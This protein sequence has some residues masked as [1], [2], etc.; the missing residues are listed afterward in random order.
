MLVGFLN[1]HASPL[2]S[3]LGFGTRSSSPHLQGHAPAAAARA[4]G[5]QQVALL[6]VSRVPQGVPQRTGVELEADDSEFPRVGGDFATKVL[7]SVL[8]RRVAHVGWLDGKGDG[9]VLQRL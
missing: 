8:W 2:F 5:P 9:L 7:D 1:H 4:V 3:R 6:F